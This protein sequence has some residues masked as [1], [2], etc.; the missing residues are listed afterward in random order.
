MSH[1]VWGA[2]PASALSLLLLGL[3][4]AA[5]LVESWVRHA[6]LDDAYISYRYADNL[7]QGQGL[8]YNP[9]ERVEGITNLL[10]TLLV[11]AGLAAGMEA[12]VAGHV[13]GLASGCAALVAAQALAGVGLARS[14]AWI[15]GLAP[16]VLLSSGAFVLWATSG[17]ETAL[18]A[19]AAAGALAAQAAGRLGWASAAA[20]AA[21]LV[22]PEGALVALVVFG[23]HL[24]SSWREGWRAWRWPAA[25]ALALLLLTGFRVAYYGSA[26]PNTFYAKVGGVPLRLGVDY[27][28]SFLRDGAVLLLPAAA[29]APL[30]DPR[31]R[32]AAVTCVLGAVYVVAVGGDVFPQGRFLVPLLPLLAALALRGVVAT[33]EAHRYAGLLLAPSIPAA[34]CWQVFGR[35]PAAVVFYL[36]LLLFAWLGAIALGRRWILPAAA[37][38]LS[39]L[40][41]TSLLAGSGADWEELQRSFRE[42]KRVADLK[43]ARTKFGVLERM[44]FM[45]AQTLLARAEPVRLVAAGAIGS[46]GYY[47]RLPI[48]DIYGIVDPEIARSEAPLPEGAVLLPGHQRSDVDRVFALEPDYILVPRPEARLSERLP[49]NL[50][51]ATH[52]DLAA[53][54]EWDVEVWGYRR[55]RGR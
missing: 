51:L 44:G 35:V 21:T 50:A 29:V 31:W 47:S 36:A 3:A 20:C 26:L 49:A 18:F 13:L 12:N 46:F 11:A 7:V 45:R 16:W 19:A 54:Y 37:A 5:F 38:V 27:L 23:F 8:V 24:G 25:F 41:A 28:L 1:A 30:L 22:R 17:M 43:R 34:I 2:A 39:G 6:Q 4:L 10:W 55:R 42:S 40:A 32:P 33:Y 48:V 52:P 15:A 53:H 9:G 14:R